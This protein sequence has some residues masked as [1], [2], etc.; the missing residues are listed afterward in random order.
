M[1]ANLE[2]LAIATLLAVARTDAALYTFP[3]SPGD[4][5]GGGLI[6]DAN[7]TGWWDTRAI[8]GVAGT[9]GSLAITLNVSGGWNSDLLAYLVHL[10]TGNQ[11]TS[12]ILLNRIG[13]TSDNPFGNTGAG[14]YLTLL[15]D[16][17]YPHDNI[18]DAA[19]GYI[20]GTY[21]PDNEAHSLA[22]F[23]GMSPNGDWTLFFA[24]LSGGG[25]STLLGW[26]LDIFIVPEPVNAALAV[27]AGVLLCVTLART[28]KVRHRL[29]DW[30]VA[31]DRW[32]DAV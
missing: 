22:A 29:H 32:I 3:F 19:S 7:P 1:T 5:S 10:D 4:G 26:G 31:I 11:T 18:H 16:P 9:I 12:V 25:Q 23:N 30:R 24:D 21:N 17:A 8:A 6:P 28:R 27:G 14:M 13:V 20:T 2:S 15:A